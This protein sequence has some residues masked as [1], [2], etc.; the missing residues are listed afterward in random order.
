M[1]SRPRIP[2]RTGESWVS[3]FNACGVTSI[4]PRS[5]KRDKATQPASEFPGTRQSPSFVTKTAGHQKNPFMSK[6]H[7][8]LCSL[9]AVAVAVEFSIPARGEEPAVEHFMIYH[10]KGRF[11]GWPANHGIWS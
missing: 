1:T 4:L 11:G 7:R 8:R 3:E 2:R 5:S 6:T 9:I 10:Q